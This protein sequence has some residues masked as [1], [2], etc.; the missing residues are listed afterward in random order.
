MTFHDYVFLIGVGVG[1]VTLGF[2]LG[3]C[4]RG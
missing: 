2:W 4:A 3:W 1:L